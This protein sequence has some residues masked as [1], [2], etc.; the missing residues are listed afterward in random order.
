MVA[1][2][3]W[4]LRRYLGEAHATPQAATAF[5][6]D[7]PQGPCYPQRSIVPG[8]LEPAHKIA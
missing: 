8:W 3:V 4:P 5:L 2:G 7:A 6:I 1:A